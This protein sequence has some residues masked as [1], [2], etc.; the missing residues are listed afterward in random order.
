V[1]CPV[2]GRAGEVP[3]T[4]PAGFE[5]CFGCGRPALEPDLLPPERRRRAVSQ[6]TLDLEARAAAAREL[7]HGR[8]LSLRQAAAEMGLGHASTVMRLLRR[9]APPS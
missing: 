6:H 7:V 3:A 2:C 1:T 4:I 9:P 8:G 5:L